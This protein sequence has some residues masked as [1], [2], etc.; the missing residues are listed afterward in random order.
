MW[1]AAMDLK[2]RKEKKKTN[3]QPK[4]TWML[5]SF[6]FQIHTLFFFFLRISPLHFFLFSF[7]VISL[8]PFALF[9]SHLSCLFILL[10]CWLQ[11]ERSLKKKKRKGIREAPFFFFFSSYYFVFLFLFYFYVGGIYTNIQ[12]IHAFFLFMYG[13]TIKKTPLFLFFPLIIAVC[14]WSQGKTEEKREKKKKKKVL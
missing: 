9:S 11:R 6:F 13:F 14:I 4:N 8:F 3:K 1:M 12:T 10:A 5:S 7:R 2:E